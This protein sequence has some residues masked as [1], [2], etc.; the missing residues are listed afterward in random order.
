MKFS[1]Q[2]RPFILYLESSNFIQSKRRTARLDS[3]VPYLALFF[4]PFSRLV[5]VFNLYIFVFDSIS[6]FL[7][8]TSPSHIPFC[9]GSYFIPRPAYICCPKQHVWPYVFQKTATK[10]F[11]GDGGFDELSGLSKSV[12]S[13]TWW[14]KPSRVAPVFWMPPFHWE[15]SESPKMYLKRGAFHLDPCSCAQKR[16]PDI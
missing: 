3:C 1:S 8:I 2:L 5:D 7:A 16:I 10:H 9:S 13:A 11:Y 15:H 4:F 6:S 14:T 12:A